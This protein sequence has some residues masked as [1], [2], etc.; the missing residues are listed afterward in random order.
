VCSENLTE[1]YVNPRRRE[2]ELK[3]EAARR[4]RQ[5]RHLVRRQLLRAQIRDRWPEIDWCPSARGNLWTKVEGLHITLFEAD[6]GYRCVVDGQFS[7][8]TYPD[9]DAVKQAALVGFEFMHAKGD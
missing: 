1:D 7:R 2:R 8:R 4:K 3:N 6:G 9:L 5:K